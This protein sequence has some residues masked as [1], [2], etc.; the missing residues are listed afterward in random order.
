MSPVAVEVGAHVGL[1]AKAWSGRQ[2]R[3]FTALEV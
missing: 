2:Q 1:E 3:W